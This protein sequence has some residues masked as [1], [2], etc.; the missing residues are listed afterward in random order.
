MRRGF[1]VSLGHFEQLLTLLEVVGGGEAV[2]AELARQRPEP[3]E[4]GLAKMTEQVEQS[5]DEFLIAIFEFVR[6]DVSGRL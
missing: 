3:V 5:C 2:A 1:H 6:F 4:L